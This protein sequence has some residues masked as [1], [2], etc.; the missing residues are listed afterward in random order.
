MKIKLLLTFTLFCY[1]L[2]IAQSAKLDRKPFAVSYIKLPSSPILDDSKRTY[3]TNSKFI[4][5]QG[6]SKVKS[7]ASLDITLD[8]HDI[9]VGEF[10]IRKEKRQQKDSDGNVTSTWY[11]YFAVVDYNSSATIQVSNA[12]TGENYKEDFYETNT[13]TSSSYRNYEGAEKY[14]YDNRNGIRKRYRSEQWVR[15]IRRIRSFLNETYGYIPY[16]TTNE[17][18]LILGS[19]KHPEFEAQQKAYEEL[20]GIFERMK[21]TEPIDAISLRLQPILESFEQ[22]AN[23]YSG[24]KRKERKVRHA[25]YYNISKIHYYLDN[26]DKAKEYAEKI[27]ETDISA[28]DGRSLLEKADRLAAKFVVNETDNRHFDIVT[29]DLTEIDIDETIEEDTQ[30]SMP[31]EPSDDILAYLITTSNDTIT[32]HIA[33]NDIAKIGYVVNVQTKDQNGAVHVNTYKAEECKTL[34]L[35]NGDIYKTIGFDEVST[36]TKLSHQ[37]LAKVLHESDQ[38][39]LFLYNQKELVL[40]S[41]EN[42]KGTSTLKPDFIF[43]VNKKLA[44]YASNCEEVASR[45]NKGEFKNNQ[46]GLLQFCNALSNCN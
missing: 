46:E 25:C 28:S 14:F 1:A 19:K 4:H 18:V 38:I 20:K 12:L 39:E 6:F 41:P 5:L 26:P 7:G 29:E 10:E 40:R 11:E 22:T 42:D 17:N 21:Y 8:Y 36:E 31:E 35:A 43:G 23:K 33:T 9:A 15:I 32:T 3:S 13:L 24:T 27:I 34:A 37:K 45:A 16:E 30:K 44:Q 2:S